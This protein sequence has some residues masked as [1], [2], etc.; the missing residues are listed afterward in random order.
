MC[1]HVVVILLIICLTP[2]TQIWPLGVC[3]NKEFKV[4]AEECLIS[5]HLQQSDE[6]G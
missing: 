4:K 1:S 6:L 2:T 5:L 3:A